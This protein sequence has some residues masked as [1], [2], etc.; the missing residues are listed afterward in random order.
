[1]KKEKTESYRRISFKSVITIVLC[2]CCI[3]AFVFAGVS[4]NEIDARAEEET[5]E[6]MND[7]FS[8]S[9]DANG[10]RGDFATDQKIYLDYDK[11]IVEAAGWLNDHNGLVNGI[12]FG[13]Y[14]VIN[15]KTFNEIKE[16]EAGKYPSVDQRTQ[17]SKG[18]V[19]TPVAVCVETNRI[20]LD[21]NRG[22]ADI[23]AMTVG[24]KDGF[25]CE[26]NGTT[27]KVEGDLMF[28]ATITADNVTTPV[29]KKVGDESVTEVEA[30]YA[31]NRGV[32]YDA[33]HAV[34]TGFRTFPLLNAANALNT[35]K[36]ISGRSLADNYMYMKE[37]IK[38]NGKSVNYWNIVEYDDTLTY[39]TNPV[40]NSGRTYSMPIVTQIQNSGE[41]K[42]W[43]HT[44]W[45]AKVGID[46]N[47][48]TIEFAE[49][50][51]F[52][53]TNGNVCRTKGL[54]KILV[55]A[56]EDSLTGYFVGEKKEVTPTVD[57]ENASEQT[58][59]K[60]LVADVTLSEAMDDV[61]W[62]MIDGYAPNADALTKILI[63][64]KSVSE[65][66]STTDTSGWDWSGGCGFSEI[67][68]LLQKPVLILCN[69]GKMTIYINGQYR[70]LL[71]NG[72]NTDVK[73]EILDGVS[74]TYQKKGTAGT[75][76]LL[77]AV[78]ETA[79]YLRTYTLKLYP[80][81]ADGEAVTSEVAHGK[82][83]DLSEYDKEGYSVK[84]TDAEGNAAFGVM[85][86]QNYSI[87]ASYTAIEYTANVEYFSGET[88]TVTYTIE[89][90]AAKLA[91][92]KQKLTA[93]TSEYE[94]VLDK[95]ELPLENCSVKEV[96]R[97][98]EYTITLKYTDGKTEEVK[99]N[100][101][102][103]AEVRA[104]LDR[105]L[106]ES[107]DEYEY[108]WK[109]G[110]PE[111]LPLENLEYEIS[112]T[113]KVYT[114]TIDYV[115]KEDEVVTF[116]VETR[117][118][119][120]ASLAE[121][122]TPAANGYTYAWVN[123]PE[124][125]EL[126][127][128]TITEKKTAVEYILT[129]VY[130]DERKEDEEYKFTVENKAE[131]YASLAEKLLASNAE[132]SY[133]WDKTELP[134]EN[135][136][137]TEIKTA[138][139]YTLT[140]KY[141]EKPDET[142]KFTVENKDEVLI[143]LAD[144]LTADS[145]AYTYGWDKTELNL[146]DTTITEQRTANEY[147]L[148]L[149]YADKAAETIKFTVETRDSVLASVKAK[150]TPSTEDYEYSWKNLPDVLELKNQTIEEKKKAIENPTPTPDSS[151]SGNNSEDN[152]TSNSGGGCGSGVLSG[153][154]LGVL[155]LFAAAMVIK[156]KKD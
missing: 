149:K 140:I 102:N 109:G 2:L 75:E 58:D 14:L 123:L 112:R 10:Y 9:V 142:L 141:T 47:N 43:I 51:P 42:I 63:N 20:R 153:S 105:K 92:I 125:L 99:F 69:G 97:P 127:N 36:Y 71:E 100:V 44:E 121:K 38:V 79:V 74:V 143:S 12:D 144:K 62:H 113:A 23:G 61:E 60:H 25:S 129:V 103:R 26:Y 76:Y 40:G 52:V 5:V 135:V 17:M 53:D 28:R 31:F 119:V 48:F 94:Y 82:T 96:R 156:K 108:S 84:W 83:I 8:V 133:K 148:T 41:Y 13:N 66:N 57:I 118:E 93:T 65:I 50:M 101:E 56:A 78:D 154:V 110:M 107:T 30:A 114:L 3:A 126:K 128:Q 137:V 155:G 88:E 77:A 46:L 145:A 81:G 34:Y 16:A 29:F 15:G 18:G 37:Y 115:E 45:A 116:T 22:Y 35:G 1:M 85:P 7:R 64:G 86:E 146:E 124:V 131:V 6:I 134:L 87:Y 91:E 54:H 55:M 21:I 24:I 33:A 4:R 139:E 39:T 68:A 90:R 49:G 11:Q 73:I 150:L 19:W 132:Y 32:E 70:D 80:D 98:V 120:L 72:K 151:D 89:N 111:T 106:T 138:V 147:T 104:E 67:N 136:T 122:L 27:F 152:K 130:S 117:A 95:A 59:L